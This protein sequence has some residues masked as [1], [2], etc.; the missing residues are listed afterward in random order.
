MSARDEL[1][2][3]VYELRKK[4]SA[5]KATKDEL[6]KKFEDNLPEETKAELIQ[7]NHLIDS[8][9]KHLDSIT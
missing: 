6:L 8:L 9:E 4:L 3:L 5:A 1:R 7:L 2:S